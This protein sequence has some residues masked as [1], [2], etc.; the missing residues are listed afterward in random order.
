[1]MDLGLAG[2]S[3][4]VTGGGRGIGRAVSVALARQGVRVGVLARNEEEVNNT[5]RNI[6]DVGGISE[7]LIADMTDPEAMAAAFEQ[8][9]TRLGPPTIMVH[10]AAGWYRPQKLYHVSE[11]E[12]REL[13]DIDICATVALFRQCLP[14][15]LDARWGR[16]VGIGSLA[17]RTGVA[18][19]TLYAM[20]KAGLEGLCRGIA[21]DYTR[22]GITANV[23]AVGFA[24]S[25]RLAGRIAGNA[26]HR[27]KLETATAT[28]RIPQPAEIA[29]VVTFLCSE[30]AAIITGSVIDATAGTHLNN[31]W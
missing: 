27:R 18:G 30:R 7:P 26:E 19:G 1:M 29:D 21:L 3:A 31:L 11:Q 17:A 10:S 24:D 9:H 15:M 6:A 16:M 5:C 22:R 4:L 14:A 2:K 25:E 8:I 12:M 13:I 20:A 23:V 28:R